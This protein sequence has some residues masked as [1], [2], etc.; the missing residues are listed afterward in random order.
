MIL[1]NWPLKKTPQKTKKSLNPT[2]ILIL[3]K[4]GKV[5]FF[6]IYNAKS[7]SMEPITKVPS[8]RAFLMVSFSRRE[9]IIN[10]KGTL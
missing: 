7:L 1:M 10:L 5:A 6:P 3:M 9:K 4:I 8:K 2:Y